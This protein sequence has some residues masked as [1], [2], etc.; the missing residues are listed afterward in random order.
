MN[1]HLRVPILLIYCF[2][3][4]PQLTFTQ[5][6][7]VIVQV[8]DGEIGADF[9]IEEEGGVRYATITSNSTA[10]SPQSSDRVIS[11]EVTFPADQ[12]YDL[13]VRYRVG[14]GGADDD[15]FFYG[16][17]FGGKDPASDAEWVRVNNIHAIGYTSNNA[18]VDGG[19]GG[20][21]GVWKWINLSEYT[22]DEPPLTFEPGTGTLTQIFQL[23]AR[24][25]GLDI[26]KIA[27]ARADYYYTVANLDEGS[28]GSPDLA[29]GGP[30]TLPIAEG[31]AKFLGS[32]YSSSQA[33]NFANYWNQVTP[34]NGG[35]W[36]TAE[37]TRD[38]MVWTQTDQAYALAKENGFPFKWH[39]L[40]WGNQQP[41]WIENLPAAEQLEEIREWFQAI[42]DRYPDIDFIEVVNEPLHDPPNRAGNGGGNYMNALGGSGTTGWDWVLEAFRLARQYFPNSELM[43]NDY[44][45]INNNAGTTDYLEIIALLQ[46]EGLIDQIGVQGHAF[47]TRNTSV[48]TIQGNLD[49]LAATG[50]PLYVT[51]LDID[52]PT[53]EVQLAEYQRVFPVFWEH[54]AVQGVTLWGYRP[55]M[56]RTDEGAFLIENNGRTERPALVWLRGYVE[57]S[58]V[59]LRER[60][61]DADRI[62]V[63]P[64]PLRSGPLRLSGA[65]G[66]EQIQVYDLAGR[67]LQYLNINSDGVT[68]DAD[69]TPGLYILKLWDGKRVYSKKLIVQ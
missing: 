21:Y 23:G 68:L 55:G 61:G 41:S 5:Y 25:D 44:N 47:S 12:P 6:A 18:V 26:D 54:P 19:G 56:W 20:G 2:F 1:H 64:N 42:A 46:A 28:D 29:T 39:V 63:Y 14:S 13:Y 31:N 52:G 9:S 10:G 17:G 69:L 22:G 34:E 67:L 51:E 66:V 11:L 49:R 65:D 37:P 32:A 3:F 57:S 43:L 36:G 38:N 45:I 30:G 27:F 53:D 58:I 62:S 8:E 50:L 48:S 24:E 59:G 16:N 33:L 60:P 35:K 40:V 4:L 7:P 15:S